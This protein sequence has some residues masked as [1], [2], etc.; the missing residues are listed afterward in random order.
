MIPK[1]YPHKNLNRKTIVFFQLSLILTLIMVLVAVEWKTDAQTYTSQ[2]VVQ[3]GMLEEE[4]MP[5]VKIPDDKLEPIPEPKKDSEDY[6][7]EK[8]IPEP[9]TKDF[10]PTKELSKDP[11]LLRLDE[12][13]KVDDDPMAEIPYE[14]IE[15]VPIFSRM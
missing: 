6:R 9:I 11:R 7:I 14:F 10:I 13:D 12:I 3:Y 4:P 5:I 15:D 1:K 2:D 8:N